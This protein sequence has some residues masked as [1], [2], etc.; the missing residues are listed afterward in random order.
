MT[1]RR[2]LLALALAGVVVLGACG[3]D[4]DDSSA[5]TNTSKTTVQQAAGDT[6]AFC[7]QMVD[8]QQMSPPEPPEGAS[9]ADVAKSMNTW[10]DDEFIPA[11]DKLEASAPAEAKDEVAKVVAFLKDKREKAFDD[12]G[13]G[14]VEAPA[15]EAAAD[16][17][18][19]DTLSVQGVEYAFKGVDGDVDA[20][21]TMISFENAGKEM[22][23]MV[24]VRKKDGV[25]DSWDSLLQAEDDS[26]VDF[27]AQAFDAP[28]GAKDTTM[29]D[30]T[31]GDYLMVCFVPVG[32]TPD[33]VDAV[34]S[35]QDQG[36][37]PHFTQGMRQEF[38][39]S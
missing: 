6:K 26:K 1:N 21:R 8:I 22:H 29:V 11:A 5:G 2:K 33:K 35:G 19:A 13:F 20:G 7:Q 38:K 36:G 25:T 9:E 23:E 10:L 15:N 32:T 39:V 14:A 17:C 31:P 27:V 16:L 30:L 34:E 12:P 4:D 28:G 18:D 24:L 3:S 37:P